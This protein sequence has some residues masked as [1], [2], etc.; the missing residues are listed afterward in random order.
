M[1]I[2]R[3]FGITFTF[4]TTEENSKNPQKPENHHLFSHVNLA[5][6]HWDQSRNFR[7]FE[8]VLTGADFPALSQ[9]YDVT[10]VTQSSLDKLHWL[11][12]VGKT[13]SG[14]I[15][16]ALFVPDIEF[17]FAAKFLHHLINCDDT[18]RSK[19][20]VHLIYPIGDMQ[21]FLARL[22]GAFK[23]D[24][25]RFADKPPKHVE[26]W[27]FHFNCSMNTAK[28]LQI[29]F[30]DHELKKAEFT[31][32]RTTY[33]YPQNLARNVARKGANTKFS[34]VLDI[35]VIPSADSARTLAKFLAINACPMCAFVIATYELDATAK[36]PQNKSELLQCVAHKKARPFHQVVFKLNQF[37]TN[38]SQ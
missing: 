16:L 6:G 37:A 34:F 31:G 29:L 36:F 27:D 35:D 17:D 9:L 23:V 15:S 3:V 4:Q 2:I 8:H 5:Q 14:P 21:L 38:F 18:L 24:F 22:D 28:V 11:S 25:H 30:S 12:Q 33:P 20:A 7:I 19:L 32:W 13:W 1:Q 26:M 10:L